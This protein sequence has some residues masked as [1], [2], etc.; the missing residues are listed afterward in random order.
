MTIQQ[1][2]L[3]KITEPRNMGEVLELVARCKEGM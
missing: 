3:T 2:R 1:W